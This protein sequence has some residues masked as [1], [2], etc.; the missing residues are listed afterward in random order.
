LGV[1]V[2]GESPRLLTTFPTKSGMPVLVSSM[3]NMK[4]RSNLRTV[5][6]TGKQR[7]FMTAAVAA[8]ATVPSSLRSIRALWRTCFDLKVSSK[9]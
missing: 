7:D 8:A 6:S 5:G 1:V 2:G 3:T 9:E 4:G